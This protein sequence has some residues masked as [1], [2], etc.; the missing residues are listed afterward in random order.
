MKTAIVK[1]IS[2]ILLWYVS[3]LFI[4]AQ[5]E[6]RVLLS[7]INKSYTGSSKKGLADGTGEARGTD[8][9]AGQFRKGFPDGEGTYIWSTG[10]TYH[11]LWKNGMRHG[12]GEYLFKFGGKDSVQAGL[13]RDDKFL[14]EEPVPPYAIEYSNSLRRVSFLRVGDRPYVK[15]EFQAGNMSNLMMLGGSGREIGNR[16]F[17][18]FEDVNFPFRGKVTFKA[19]NALRTTMLSCELWIVINQPGSWQISISY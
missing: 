10:E 14:G 16:S 6:V 2:F 11:G 13:W 9:Y 12:K 5:N 7:G 8:S 15:Y 3:T 1:L 18:G 4:Y 19:P 17:T